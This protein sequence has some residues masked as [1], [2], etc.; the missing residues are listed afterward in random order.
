[1]DFYPYY[2]RRNFSKII[3]LMFCKLRKN[4]HFRAFIS[5]KAHKTAV[6]GELTAMVDFVQA[7]VLLS[8][9][10]GQLQV[11]PCYPP[12]FLHLCFSV[13]ISKQLYLCHGLDR[14]AGNMLIVNIYRFTVK[15]YAEDK[16]L[17]FTFAVIPVLKA[18]TIRRF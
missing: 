11:S 12:C 13:P 17:P 14:S 4:Q 5:C 8:R 6:A 10:H 2:N 7:Q 9:P 1:M 15:V 3:P 16:K 18:N